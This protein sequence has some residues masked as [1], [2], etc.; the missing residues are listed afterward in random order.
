LNPASDLVTKLWRLCTLLRKDGI[1][2]QQY[3]TE[4][5]Y[6]LFLKMASEQRDE[7]KIPA[8][9]R[10]GAIKAANEADVLQNYRK[11]LVDLGDPEK[12]ADRSI[13]A[14]FQ[15]ATTVVREPATLTRL[16]EAIDGLHWFTAERD[17]FGDAYEGLLQKMAEETRARRRAILHPARADRGH[18]RTDAARPGEVIQDPASGTGGFLIAADHAMRAATDDYF[19]LSPHSRNSSLARPSGASRTCPIPS[20]CC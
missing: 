3:V 13:V 10:W 15:N 11:A 18:G 19:E 5:T 16:I 20:A 14:I 12:V 2:Y 1:T 17:A 9:Y 8:A 7:G 6:L 4:L